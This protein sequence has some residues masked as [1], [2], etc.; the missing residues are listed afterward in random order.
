MNCYICGGSLVSRDMHTIGKKKFHK[1]CWF[2][3]GK[4][5]QK[6]IQENCMLKLGKK[7]L[8]YDVTEEHFDRGSL[9]F[10]N[11]SKNIPIL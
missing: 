5:E 9:D 11:K 6:L 2:R 8:G 1:N 3:L 10:V 7:T 4:K